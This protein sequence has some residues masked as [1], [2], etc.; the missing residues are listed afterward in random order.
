MYS[1]L[2][3][4]E[5]A[6]ETN[7]RTKSTCVFPTTYTYLYIARICLFAND[8]AIYLPSRSG[9]MT[10]DVRSFLRSERQP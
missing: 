9:E 10:K 1:H 8:R 2:S 5:V 4:N 6:G 7:T 3:N